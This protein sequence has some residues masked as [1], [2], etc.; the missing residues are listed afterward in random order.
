MNENEIF[1]D[2]IEETDLMTDEDLS[3]IIKDDDEIDGR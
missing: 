2:I 1:D 3:E